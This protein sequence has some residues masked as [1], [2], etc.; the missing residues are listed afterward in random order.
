M[1]R[2]EHSSIHVRLSSVVELSWAEL[3]CVNDW[4][5]CSWM[6]PQRG[7][8]LH[9]IM[10]IICIKNALV[11][12]NEEHIYAF[13]SISIGILR[14]SL[15]LTAAS[16]HHIHFN[17]SLFLDLGPVNAYG[18]FLLLYLHRSIQHVNFVL[19]LYYQLILTNS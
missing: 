3:I 17:R 11:S 1:E 13:I 15:M 7:M 19:K 10:M 18:C 12:L 5:L 16:L 8:E 9:Y 14:W 2:I 6:A 4:W